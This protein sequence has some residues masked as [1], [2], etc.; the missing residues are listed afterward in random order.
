[1]IKYF[2]LLASFSSLTAA[3]ADSLWNDNTANIYSYKINYKVGDSIELNVNEQSAINYKEQ[4]KSTKSINVNIQG[5]EMTGILSFIPKGNIDENK[6]SSDNDNLQ[7]RTVLQGRIT[8]IGDGFVTVN[9]SKTITINNRTSSVQLTGEASFS[10][11]IGKKIVSS[12]LVNPRLTITTLFENKNTVLANNDF[13]TVITN[14]DA[15]NDKDKKSE[16]KL[17]E[18]KKKELLLNYFNKVLNVI[19]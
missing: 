4:S 8:N 16:T 18:A 5:G 12:K 1:M 6:N 7:I 9:A 19:F 15:T 13:T 17:N 2:L 14:P 3:F 10:D 11:I